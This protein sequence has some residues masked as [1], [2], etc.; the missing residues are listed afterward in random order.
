MRPVAL[1]EMKIESFRYWNDERGLLFS[2]TLDLSPS[3]ESFF[4]RIDSMTA[5]TISLLTNC[6]NDQFGPFLRWSKKFMGWEEKFKQQTD[7]WLSR[8]NL[9]HSSIMQLPAKSIPNCYLVHH[10]ELERFTLGG[11]IITPLELDSSSERRH[12]FLFNVTGDTHT[13]EDRE[14]EVELVTKKNG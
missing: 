6:F 2:C 7:D 8:V 1:R 10:L 12:S 5:T 3:K 4:S 14:K 11:L 13:H 9:F